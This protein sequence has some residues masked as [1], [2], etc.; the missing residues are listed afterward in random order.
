MIRPRQT[1]S[2][3]CII[4]IFREQKVSSKNLFNQLR[5]VFKYFKYFKYFSISSIVFKYTFCIIISDYEYIDWYTIIY[6]L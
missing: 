1:R 3:A 4:L 2:N 6:D 5:L